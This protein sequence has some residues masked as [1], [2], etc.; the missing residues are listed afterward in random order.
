MNRDHITRQVVAYKKLKAMENDKTIMPIKWSQLLI[1]G[2]FLQEVFIIGICLE[3]FG[4]L[5]R[6]LL[7]I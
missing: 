6:W 3:N 1:R 7:V 5:D 4:F 2:G